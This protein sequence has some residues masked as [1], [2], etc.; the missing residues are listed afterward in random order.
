MGHNLDGS[1]RAGRE[2]ETLTTKKLGFQWRHYEAIAELLAQEGFQP[3]SS[4]VGAFERMFEH[5]NG[6]FSR[7]RFERALQAGRQSITDDDTDTD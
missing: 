6:L 1:L 2:D 5:D 7:N 3:A 4:L